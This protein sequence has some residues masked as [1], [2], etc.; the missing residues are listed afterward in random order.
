MTAKREPDG[1]GWVPTM[2]APMSSKSAPMRMSAGVRSVDQ[3]RVETA[4][5]PA[6]L[7]LVAKPSS[8]TRA[9]RSSPWPVTMRRISGGSEIVVI[10]F[11]PACGG[12]HD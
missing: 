3:I 5:L 1:G 9:T 8:I 6:C 12:G 10:L 7:A 11:P 4:P 2:R